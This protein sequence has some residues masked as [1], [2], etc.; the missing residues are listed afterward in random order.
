MERQ[1]SNKVGSTFQEVEMYKHCVTQFA[2]DWR[3]L[4]WQPVHSGWFADQYRI[5][6]VFVSFPTERRNVDIRACTFWVTATA[7]S[8]LMRMSLPC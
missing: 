5:F 8:C 3:A 7:R 6:Y 4:T 1:W 2:I